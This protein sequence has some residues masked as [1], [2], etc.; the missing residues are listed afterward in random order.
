MEAT[1]DSS[2]YP[3]HYWVLL[4]FIGYRLNKLKPIREFLSTVIKQV[5]EIVGWSCSLIYD[6]WSRAEEPGCSW[7]RK[8]IIRPW[9]GPFHIPV[10]GAM[11]LRQGLF[12]L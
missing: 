10:E 12:C 3:C 4:D 11:V 8:E 2:V 1:T 9:A 6:F 7:A 5:A